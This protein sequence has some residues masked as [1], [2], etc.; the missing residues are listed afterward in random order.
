M[1]P[2]SKKKIVILVKQPTDGRRALW[3]DCQRFRKSREP[4]GDEFAR[5]PREKGQKSCIQSSDHFL[6]ALILIFGFLTSTGQD[7]N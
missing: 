7:S 3:F 6:M 4:T 5:C 1:W 2:D